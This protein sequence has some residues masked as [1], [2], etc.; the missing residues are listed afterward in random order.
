MSKTAQASIVFKPDGTGHGLYT[1]VIDLS[2]LGRLQV[3]RATTIEFDNRLQVWRVKERTGLSLFMSP[4]RET[5]L[6]WER[7]HFLGEEE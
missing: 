6:Y 4:S 7:Q 3:E 1:E 5:C 2:R